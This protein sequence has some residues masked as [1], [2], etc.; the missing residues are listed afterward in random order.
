MFFS[1]KA[2]KLA[3]LMFCSALLISCGQDEEEVKQS[4]VVEQPK[5]AVSFQVDLEKAK[6]TVGDVEIVERA[7]QGDFRRVRTMLENKSG[8]INSID[9]AGVTP[10][11]A[12]ANNG[13]VETVDLLLDYIEKGDAKNLDA[14]DSLGKTALYYAVE[15][16]RPEIVERL[17]KHG[18]NPNLYTNGGMF[19]IHQAITQ[20][21]MNIA[22]ILL[23]D[24]NGAIKT[25]PN[26]ADKNGQSPLMLAASK[27]DK[28]LINLLGKNSANFEQE[29][30]AGMTVLMQAVADN[31]K[32][33]VGYLLQQGAKI[34]TLSDTG[35]TALIIALKKNYTDLARHLL[36]KNADVSIHKAESDSPLEVAVANDNADAVLVRAIMGKLEQTGNPI[37]SEALWKSI[38]KGNY[39]VVKLLIDSGIKI[40]TFEKADD[41]ILLRALEIEEPQIAILAVENGA[42]IN[43][44]NKDGYSPLALAIKN[45]H[46][47]LGK[48]LL[49]KNAETE[50]KTQNPAAI[51]LN[52]VL[53]TENAGFLDL[54]MAKNSK[55]S[56]NKLLIQAVIDSKPALLPV[57][58]K[59]GANPN[60]SDSLGKPV[61]WL[62]VA[63]N[64]MENIQ[65]LLA[66]GA[67]INSRDAQ[68][69]ATPLMIAIAA[70]NEPMA[71]FLLSVN[72]DPNIL[73]NEGLSA[74]AYAILIDQPEII[75][76]LEAGGADVNAK[77]KFGNSLTYVI[78]KSQL[79]GGRKQ[80]MLDLLISL[81]LKN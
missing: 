46:L 38:R 81:G 54:M 61:L 36:I 57:S 69:G 9:Q 76:T 32:E 26:I 53:Q 8:A 56:P 49:D 31:N 24:L 35:Q 71:R 64:N 30:F 22:E 75:K 27:G 73:D 63:K 37:E 43:K 65:N 4:D 7:A 13:R 74:L 17:R 72:A 58:L 47:E 80:A 51:P 70:R 28:E 67:E 10:L 21:E 19:P 25:N 52:I 5:A 40:A 66:A 14:G 79:S 1:N 44:L 29:D 6:I 50:P 39:E 23:E 33:M 16:R 42:D 59:Y 62:A 34:N 41:N 77:D 15:F 11:I 12:A 68:K 78:D 45:N 55:F 60:V 48:I 18:A 20:G 2:Q 3:I